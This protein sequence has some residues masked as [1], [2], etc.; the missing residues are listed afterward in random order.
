M[1]T[2]STAA[3]A[4]SEGQMKVLLVNPRIDNMITTNLPCY[5]DEQR[6]YNPPLGLMYV[7][8]Y[9]E[10]HTNC[11][12]QILDMLAEEVT[13]EQLENELRKRKPDIIGITTTTF[14]L[15]DAMIVAKIAKATDKGARVVIGG[16]H[17]HIYPEETISLPEVDFLVLGE[18]EL[19][20]AELL[21]KIDDYESLKGVKGIVFKHEGEIINTGWAGLIED[22]DSLPFPARHLTKVRKYG[23]LLAKGTVVSTMMSSRGCP[24]NCLF[25]HRPH[26]GKKFRP[27]SAA[28]VVEEMEECVDMGIEEILVYDDTFTID[29]QR[30]MDIC[31]LILERGLSM[32]WDIRARVDTVDME[33]LR[34]LKKAGCERIH[35]GIESANP[36]IL[37]VLRKGITLPQ[38][39]SAFSMSKEVGISTL[40]YFMLGSPTETREQIMNTID[41]AKR[42]EP[43]YCHFSVTT[44]YPATPL[45]EM[46]LKEGMFSDYW[47]KFAANPRREF[48]T[49]FWEEDLSRDELI[50]LLDYAYKSFYTRP[51]YVLGQLRRVRS[52]SEF[53]RKARA[54][55]R[56]LKP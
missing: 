1:T 44:P 48:T 16:P 45:Y 25:C 23:S 39:E 42:L 6:G 41:Y 46:G 7:A 5:V 20:F 22:L 21:E 47:R 40:A 2:S 14:T 12:I 38:V 15:I 51:A 50:H 37:K 28:N 36:E 34:A 10:Q 9:A 30:V 31:R 3:R 8:A 29:R 26:L 49:R 17:A 13:Y 55:L 32:T 19:A 24:H 18:G 54:A 53:A 56:V 4:K 43:D 11:E 27:R 35:Y 52:F 33:M